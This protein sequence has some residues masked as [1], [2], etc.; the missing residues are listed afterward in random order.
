MGTEAPGSDWVVRGGEA[1]ATDL[2]SGYG[3]HPLVPGLYG[4]S[5]QSAPGKTVSELAQAGRCPNATISYE[6]VVAL[7]QVVQ[8][9]GYEMRLVPSPGGGY[10]HTF[11]VV[12]DATKVMQTL[13][14]NV[15][16]QAL[17]TTFRRMPNPH[18]APRSPRKP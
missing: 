2:I 14:P 16:A 4:F 1:K 9:V 17:T 15:V 5:V 13:L 8:S 12:Y 3:P 18:R 10:H 7:A 6:T 11:A